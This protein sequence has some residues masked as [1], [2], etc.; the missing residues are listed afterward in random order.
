MCRCQQLA[1]GLLSQHQALSPNLQQIRGVGLAMLEL[2]AAQTACGET[3]KM[4][5]EVCKQ[6]WL[7]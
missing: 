4:L 7:V 5:P 6:P 3:R 2:L 1:W